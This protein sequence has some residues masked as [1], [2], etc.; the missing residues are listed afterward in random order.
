MRCCLVHE[1]APELLNDPAVEF[2]Q[3]YFRRQPQTPEEIEHAIRAIGV[4]ETAALRYGGTDQ[5]IIR[6][7]GG[8]CCDH[9]LQQEK[10]D[11][12]PMQRTGAAG[13][14]TC[15]RKLLGRGSGR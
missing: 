5:A 14:F 15:I 10:R 11:N 13:I 8:E 1:E 3:C 7:L 4:S 9:Q 6:R 2:Q 12:Q